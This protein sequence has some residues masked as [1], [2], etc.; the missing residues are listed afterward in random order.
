MDNNV[1]SR[2]LIPG[3]EWLYYKIYTG[4]KTSDAILVDFIKPMTHGLLEKSIIKSWFFIRYADPKH[5]L[6]L[7]FQVSKVD[8]IG[9]LINSLYPHLKRL[10]DQ[11]LIWKIQMDTYHRELERYGTTTMELSEQLFFHDSRCV[12]DFLDIIEGDEGEELR[13]LFAL[14]AMDNFLDVFKYAD[15]EKLELLDRL[16]TGFGIEFGMSR[17][18]KKQL[19]DKYRAQRKKMEQFM[20]L[21]KQDAADYHPI[22]EILGKRELEM[23]PLAHSII[24]QNLHQALQV[25]YNDLMSSYLH[26]F[27]NRL[28]KSKNRLHELVCYDFLYRYYKS[29]IAR[30]KYQRTDTVVD[31]K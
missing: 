27:M 14:K 29:I 11:D 21:K 17:P 25:G 5:H 28:F 4:P 13:W 20:A 12:V 2:S 8:R 9:E 31:L 3:D 26:M 30:K 1:I 23:T 10:V 7:R 24:D 18:L 22:F 19:D 15:N 6:R 16:K